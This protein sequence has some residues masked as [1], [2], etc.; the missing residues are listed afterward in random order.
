[1]KAAAKGLL[2]KGRK[3][4]VAA[5]GKPAAKPQGKKQSAVRK[6]AVKV[7]ASAISTVRDVREAVGNAFLGGTPGVDGKRRKKE[8]DTGGKSGK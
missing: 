4:V 3:K 7:L 5:T 1:M 6:V 8:E 2:A